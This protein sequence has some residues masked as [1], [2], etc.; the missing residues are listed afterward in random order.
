MK[1]EHKSSKAAFN[2][3]VLTITLESQQEVDA[4]RRVTNSHV[5]EWNEVDSIVADTLREEI[6]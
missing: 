6:V 5:T 4:L 1:I 2:P 3:I